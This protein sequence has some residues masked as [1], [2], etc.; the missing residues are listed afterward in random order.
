[1]PDL[2]PTNGAAGQKRRL[3]PGAIEPHPTECALVVHYLI[4]SPPDDP[5]PSTK[6][7]SLKSLGPSANLPCISQEI[8]VKCKLIHPAKQPLVEQVL[9]TLQSRHAMRVPSGRA[10]SS[11]PVLSSSS[12]RPPASTSGRNSALGSEGSLW[13][14]NSNSVPDDDEEFASL[15]MLDQYVDL[16]YEDAPAKLRATGLI[17]ALAMQHGNLPL[18][19]EKEYLFSALSRTLREET[20]KSLELSANIIAIFHQFAMYPPYHPLLTANKVGDMCMKLLDQEIKR[21]DALTAN[22][23]GTADATALPP[24]SARKPATSAKPAGSNPK[25]AAVLAKQDALLY[26]VVSIL[27][28]QATD[29]DFQVKMVKRGIVPALA[30]LA[31]RP[32]Q[33]VHVM[34]IMARFLIVLAQYRENVEALRAA[35]ER[36]AALI[37][38]IGSRNAELQEAT[39]KLFLNLSHDGEWRNELIRMG[40]VSA[41]VDKLHGEV[42]TPELL[43]LL[44]QI[45]CDERSKAMFT[46]NDALP[47]LLHL[48]LTY[49][50]DHLPPELMALAINLAV[51]EHNAELWADNG[52]LTALFKRLMKSRDY[53][54]LKMLRNMSLH[55]ELHMLFLD[56]LDDLLTLFTTT[57]AADTHVELLGILANLRVPDL[58]YAALAHAYPTLLPSL[59]RYLAALN[60]DDLVL[61]A[62]QFV[63]AAASDTGIDD[64][65]V[66][67]RIPGLVLAVMRSHEDDDEMVLQSLLACTAMVRHLPACRAVLLDDLVPASLDVVYDQHPAIR[68]AADAGLDAVADLVAADGGAEGGGGGVEAW[69]D[70]IRRD[71]FHFHN[72]EWIALA[73]MAHEGHEGGEKEDKKGER[74]EEEEVGGE[75]VHDH[76]D[77]STH[78]VADTFGHVKLVYA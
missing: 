32:T 70:R 52:G 58:D 60:G 4:V 18:L 5:I 62:V 28:H 17:L 36:V 42:V 25:V 22:G 68:A 20:I 40:V 67:H 53:L 15:E 29:P 41:L 51:N 34:L 55:P 11:R 35:P 73:T 10:P 1:M 46:Y 37:P 6:T 3:I 31:D 12:P 21:L 64:H 65:F 26:G 54:L 7:I 43:L 23:G 59:A 72:A 71:K 13:G 45:S 69:A 24:A 50:K 39:L 27:L 2:A 76:H 49:P 66:Q 61:E 78:H 33:N 74:H 77:G 44:Y 48:V 47:T 57:S 14:M 75:D 19:A 63:C 9:A 38:L 56:H 16:L 30:R 8:I